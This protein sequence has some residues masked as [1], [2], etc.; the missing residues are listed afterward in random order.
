MK[1]KNV[2]ALF[3]SVVLL[4]SLFAGCG[5]ETETAEESAS[6]E[7]SEESDAAEET[8]VSTDGD[9]ADNASEETDTTED[10]EVSMGP[11]YYYL[12]EETTNVTIMFQYASFYSSFYPEG[13]SS[14]PFW[15]ALG[16]KL[17]CT[18][19]LTEIPNTTYAEKLNLAI[20]SGTTPDL[21]TGINTVYS[22]GGAGALRDEVVYDLREY[23]EEYAP[24]YWAYVTQDETTLRATMTDDGEIYAMY[25]L[26]TELSDMENDG[27]WIR[28]DWLNELGYSVPST[29]DEL[30]EFLLACKE[31]YGC[32]SAF[33]QMINTNNEFGITAVGIWNAF[34]P[35]GYYVKDDGTVGFGPSE[36]YYFDYLEYLQLL[37]SEGLFLTS[38]MTDAT[39]SELFA[40]G[41]IA[42][43]G[44]SPENV[45]AYLALLDDAD[46]SMVAMP[47]LGEPT[48]Y[49][50]VQT[51]MNN[52]GISS[53]ALSVSTT[54]DTPEL[55]VKIIDYLYTEEGSM[56][57]TYG[58]EGLTYEMVD[59][60]PQYTD[61][62]INNPDGIPVRATLGYYA[63]PGMCG[64]TVT[65]RTEYTF[66]DY[67][68]EATDI[69]ASAYTGTSG[70]LPTS[71]LTFT[72]DEM[73]AMSVY[74]SDMYTYITEFVYDVV[75]NGTELTD[76][77]K[78][79][80]LDTLENTMHLSEIL[81]I[82]DAA[83][84]R[85]LSRSLD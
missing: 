51:Y 6:A 12:Q 17:N 24:N 50:D 66:E 18:F 74:R 84:Q 58:I 15:D 42:V 45:P 28:E 38:E 70:T 33:Y 72:D 79:E 36:D 8:T 22:T 11:D 76:Q 13:W 20:V 80:Y 5:S 67:Q 9:T 39:S 19:E 82:Y 32:E 30:Y 85:Y 3:L 61:L 27:L 2:L 10:A 75:F 63:T 35:T 48:E 14:S 69:W 23:L 59:G 77:I 64:L 44:D 4:L 34:G 1:H 46:A 37:A 26:M 71:A 31:A 73:E 83:Y 29:T 60:E 25:N 65:G 54:C 52:D 68:L 47:A 21:L 41:D 81:T 78:E 7:V 43:N 40:S 16:E 53:A 55:M 62:V 57:A 49:G 56:L